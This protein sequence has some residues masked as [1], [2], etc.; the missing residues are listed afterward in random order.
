MINTLLNA[1]QFS[2]QPYQFHISALSLLLAPSSSNQ[3]PIKSLTSFTKA[4]RITSPFLQSF[5]RGYHRFQKV[6]TRVLFSNFLGP[7]FPRPIFQLPPN[8]PFPTLL[9]SNNRQVGRSSHPILPF[10][11]GQSVLS[12]GIDHTYFL[13]SNFIDLLQL[14]SLALYTIYQVS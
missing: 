2:Q 5:L 10:L 7:F 14:L 1:Y 9:D 8:R 11:N 13:A 12:I 6:I 3:C 4:S